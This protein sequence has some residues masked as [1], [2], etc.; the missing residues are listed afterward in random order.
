MTKF[1]EYYDNFNQLQSEREKNYLNKWSPLIKEKEYEKEK[2]I[3]QGI[4]K[5]NKNINEILEKQREK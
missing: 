3:G 4:F 1:K 2:I 5:S